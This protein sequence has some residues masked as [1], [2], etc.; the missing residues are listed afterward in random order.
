M[1]PTLPRTGRTAPRRSGRTG[2]YDQPSRYRRLSATRNHPV[3]KDMGERILQMLERSGG[4]TSHSIAAFFSRIPLYDVRR[5]LF[6]HPD[7]VYVGPDGLWAAR[8]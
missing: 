5:W 1:T 3:R 6:D 7:L 2:L 8:E 4:M